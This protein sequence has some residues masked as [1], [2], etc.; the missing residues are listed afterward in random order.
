MV[1]GVTP[2]AFL[3]RPTFMPKPEFK[4]SK[5]LSIQAAVGPGDAALQEPL[6][7]TLERWR[8]EA[9]VFVREGAYDWL[10]SRIPGQRIL[11][12]GCGFG[13]STAA[14]KNAGKNVFALDNRMDCL[15]T[16][17]DKVDG[18][19][20]GLADVRYYD[21]RL[22]AD[23]NEFAPD[24]VVC[25]MAGAPADDLPRDVPPTYATMQHRLDLQRAV[26]ALA[27]RLPTA[28]T[29]HLADRTA[30]P[31]KMKDAG[32]QTWF[33]MLQAAVIP[34]SAFTLDE[35]DIVFRKL[36]LGQPIPGSSALA[37]VVPVLGEAS[38]K[39]GHNVD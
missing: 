22:L 23:L 13:A 28:H 1:Y 12:I 9:A 21:E 31:W 5:T 4:G 17:R 15:E 19:M 3:W 24:A 7:Q 10:A 33:R 39:R 35:K 38:F 30:F 27:S 34:G 32:R 37:G 6:D 26:V 36:T 18:L 11:E 29:L 20:L 25:W 2:M 14:L 16:T 8:E